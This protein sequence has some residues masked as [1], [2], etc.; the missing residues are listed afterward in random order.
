VTPG[1]HICISMPTKAV[2]WIALDLSYSETARG[3][4]HGDAQDTHNNTRGAH[5]ETDK[6]T[7]LFTVQTNNMYTVYIDVRYITVLPW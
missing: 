5:I 3:V 1:G 7:T 2:F 4:Y 6:H